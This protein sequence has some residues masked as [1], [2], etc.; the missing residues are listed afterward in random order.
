MSIGVSISLLL[1]L[2][3]IL[4]LAFAIGAYVYRDARRRG[5]NAVLWCLIAVFAPSLI[6]LII[7]MLIRGNY[8]DLRCPQCSTPVKEQYVICPNCGTKL[9][10]SC[11]NCAM[12]VEI[13][14]KICPKC[15]SPLPEYQNDIHAP[16]HTKDKSIWKILI[17]VILI[18]V[19]LIAIMVFA[20]SATLGGGSCSIGE[21]TIEEYQKE[22]EVPEIRENVMQWLDSLDL[23]SKHAYALRYDHK[24]DTDTEYF[25]LLY[26]PGA[27]NQTDTGFGQSSSIFGTT[28]KIELERTG[29]SGSFFCL[30]SSADKA[31]R[32]EII[33]DGEKIPCDV[34]T[35]DYNPTTFYIEPDYDELISKES[36]EAAA[37]TLQTLTIRKVKLGECVDEFKIP[38]EDL[39]TD[40]LIFLRHVDLLPEDHKIHTFANNQDY[41]E[42]VMVYGNADSSETETFIT[43]VFEHEGYYYLYESFPSTEPFTYY[44]TTEDFYY[45]LENLFS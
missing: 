35:V 6:G 25:F 22:H 41:Y 7:Y 24:T 15:T 29:S 4:I 45:T 39:T 3:I 23:E 20:F 9:R 11:P 43:R 21:I 44:Q 10:P 37:L 28:F 13:D 17:I 12:P 14:W 18:P 34:T 30:A 36:E 16:V 38:Y 40:I 32:L 1:M 31:P 8:S 5:M 26:V 42:I 33:L 19:L 27:G 2:I